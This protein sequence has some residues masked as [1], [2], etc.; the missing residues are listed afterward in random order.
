[1]KPEEA[2]REII[3]AKLTE[4]GWCV[5][6]YD[7]M[8]LAA[9]DGLAVT[10][11]PGA[12]GPADYLLYVDCKAIGV[13]E[14]KPVGHTLKGVEGQSASYAEGLD[15]NLPVWST[16]LPF[17]FE[18]T[19]E[20]TQFTNWLEPHARSREVF[21]FFR[22]ES[23]R[24]IFG[25]EKQLRGALRE[26]PE[27]VQGNLW[28]KQHTAIEKLERS[29]ARGKPK[30]LIQMATGSGKTF[31]AANIAYRLVRHAHARRI[32]FLV[33]RKNLGLQT[34]KE[35]QAFQPPGESQ[36]FDKLFNIDHP[37]KSQ[38][39]PVNNVII[40]TIQ[41]LYSTLTGGPEVEEDDEERSS[42]E[43]PPAFN[44]PPVPVGY[45]ADLPPE[46]FDVL[47]VDEC[48]R[49][50]Y[51]VWGDVL[52]Y[53]DAFTIGLTATPSKQTIAFFDQNLVME[54][55]HEEAVADRV[56]VPYDVYEIRTQITEQGS[57]VDAGYYV[58]KRSRKT[59]KERQA[60][61]DDDLSYDSKDLDNAVVAVDQIRTV[62]QAFRDKLFSEIFP[63]RTE[64]PKT[65]IF[66]KDDSHAD[67]IVDIV[68]DEFGLGND[69]CQ[70]ITYRTGRMR[71]TVK[72]KDPDGT[73]REE[74]K[75]VKT[76]G[77][78]GEDVLTAFRNSFNPRIA[79][80]VDMIATGTDVK[81]VEIVFFMRTVRSGN[82]FEQMK[83]RGVRV[84]SPDE[85]AKT[86]PPIENKDGEILK[87]LAKTR[88]V[89]VDAVGA[90][91]QCKSERGPVDRQPSKTLKQ[92]FDHIKAGGTDPDAVS[93]LAGKL[94]RLAHE[95]S[96]D[97]VDDV[98]K[99]AHGKTLAT[100]I[101]DLMKSTNAD[102]VHAKAM[103]TLPA[104][105][106]PT[107]EQ[108]NEAEQSLIRDAV[109]PF[110]DPKLRDLL[111]DIKLANE[112]TIDRI[113]QDQ[114]LNAGYSQEARDR[115]KTKIDSFKKFIEDNRSELT[116][117]Q[118]FYSGMTASRLKFCD[119]KEVA[120]RIAKPPLSTTPDD[121]WRCYETLE[122]SKIEGKGGQLV[123][124][125]VTLIRHT[126]DPSTPLLPFEEMVQERYAIWRQQ[127]AAAGV[128]FTADQSE[129]L[130][131][132]AEHIGNSLAIELEDF[133]YDW[134]GQRG[135]LGRAQELFGDDLRRIVDE[136]NE[137]LAA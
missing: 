133:Q 47:I 101:T 56:N 129:W 27:L 55:T 88:F 59:R 93:A 52:K 50:I 17:V 107:D 70:K 73:E 60:Q 31:T 126:L 37:K 109:R 32:C 98:Q 92:V 137:A 38:F 136:L 3:D 53:F 77:K 21:S 63:G 104:D 30:A 4:A 97:Q 130:D 64:V 78:T 7:E 135:S 20:V 75:Y 105:A 62:V 128:E 74:V 123:T 112:Q 49:S 79:V 54:Y 18:S 34:L 113:S 13:V 83:G 46:F 26:M 61:L 116:A 102:G 40:T 132:I 66:A 84:I 80:T 103:E 72:V 85:L 43:G 35:F 96:A 51:S 95:M 118:V 57:D 45:N 29:L 39:A 125:L 100:L 114:L 134:F 28:P 71:T 67:D 82:Y 24:T 131:K 121:L 119:L 25:R 58:G 89:I 122:K 65:I 48:H 22:P 14:A 1:M 69:F 15:K 8:N 44:K 5:Q 108:L 10:E 90:C 99:H 94:S 115:A 110:Y 11:F 16:P 117:L 19:G 41:R 68:R 127:Q 6:T 42:F 124:D 87:K 9:G 111:L 36:T 120:N 12:H 91:K 106:E 23:L 76:K 81:P 2:A 86:T 33:D